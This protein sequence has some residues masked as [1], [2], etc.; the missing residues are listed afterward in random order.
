MHNGLSAG[1]FLCIAPLHPLPPIVLSSCMVW[2]AL[3]GSRTS[4]T[5]SEGLLPS[6]CCTRAMQSLCM[7]CQR[8][9]RVLMQAA[10]TQLG[11]E[12]TSVFSKLT[13]A[14]WTGLILRTQ[15]L[16]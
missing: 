3:L 7:A 16:P 8:P 5:P 1:A 10:L 4:P 9:L 14:Q 6:A 15:P 11:G 12:Q 2:C 13:F